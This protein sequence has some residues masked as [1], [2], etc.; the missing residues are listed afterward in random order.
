MNTANTGSEI[1]TSRVNSFSTD[2][3]IFAVFRIQVKG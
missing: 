1:Y 3:T 2:I